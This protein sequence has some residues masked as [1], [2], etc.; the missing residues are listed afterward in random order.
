M[1][2]GNS[3]KTEDR[4]KKLNIQYP[5]PQSGI[6]QGGKYPTDEGKAESGRLKERSQESKKVTGDW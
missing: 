4:N 1:S 3:R 6:P 5:V 2:K